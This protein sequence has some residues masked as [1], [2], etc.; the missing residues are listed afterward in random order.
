MNETTNGRA[1]AVPDAAAPIAR[2]LGLDDERLE[3]LQRMHRDLHPQEFVLFLAVAART[4]LDPYL[5]QIY[6]I[7]DKR[8]GNFYIHVGIDGRRL[9][10]QRTGMVDG[11]IG[12]QWCGPDGL[13]LDVWLDDGP[14]A[15]ARF[16]V[17]KKGCR[18][19]FWGVARYKSFKGV[20]PNWE[21]RPDHQLAKVAEDH[22]YRKAFPYEMGG[23][24]AYRPDLDAAEPEASATDAEAEYREVDRATGEI[25]EAAPD[26]EETF[27]DL[28]TAPADVEEVDQ[29]RMVDAP[30]ERT[31]RAWRKY[32]EAHAKAVAAGFEP[33][34]MRDTVSEQVLVDTTNRLLRAVASKQPAG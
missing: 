33:V 10:A 18:E 30:T 23:T 27:E 29:P 21:Q 8:N 3:I 14:P 13:W 1:L 26:A 34:V 19:P 17:L 20:G 9:I 31:D 7:K 16:G 2:E 25:T 5:K 24:P 6:A 12:P 22:A 4:G 15:A 32:K 28:A 11:S